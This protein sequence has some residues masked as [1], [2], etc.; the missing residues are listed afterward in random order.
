SILNLGLFLEKHGSPHSVSSG[1]S[2]RYQL[3]VENTQCASISSGVANDVDLRDILD[4]HH[5]LFEN[6][7]GCGPKT[8]RGVR[9]CG[10]FK[11]TVNSYLSID[12]YVLSTFEDISAKIAGG[13]QYSIID[14]REA[15][16]QLQVEQESRKFLVVSTHIGLY[17]Y[18]RL[19]FGICSAP[20]IFL[21]YMDQL[22]HDIPMTTVYLDD[23]IISGGSRTDNLQNLKS[24]FV[25]LREA[26][27]L[28]KSKKCGFLQDQVDF[29]S[30]TF[31]NDTIKPSKK[32][33][34]L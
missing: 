13:V 4:S 2:V 5:E 29:L 23:I 1:P 24:V 33:K 14:L 25:R 31:H 28:V 3:I 20:V 22:L 17:R 11:V 12:P 34:Q 10:D 21:S 7:R 19:S 6:T 8:R 15:Y 9:I 26:G 16:L 32:S 30:N 27:I 18:T